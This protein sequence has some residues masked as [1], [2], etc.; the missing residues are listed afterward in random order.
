MEHLD[1]RA[2]LTNFGSCTS[3]TLYLPKAPFQEDVMECLAIISHNSFRAIGFHKN[4]S[5]TSPYRPALQGSQLITLPN[6]PQVQTYF[7]P[8]PVYS[9]ISQHIPGYSTPFQPI[10]AY[11]S[12]SSLFQPLPAYSSLLQLIPAYFSLFQSI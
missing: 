1:T 3:T 2:H 5:P 7:Y 9:S 10:P 4:R 6:L 12:L 11:S 8:I